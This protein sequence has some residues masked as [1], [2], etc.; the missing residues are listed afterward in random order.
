MNRS[1]VQ[2]FA[3]NTSLLL[4]VAPAKATIYNEAVSGD[5]SNNQAAPT[6]LMLTPGLNS[7]IGTVGLTDHQDWVSFT[8]PTGYMMT[9]YVNSKYNSTDDQ[10]FTGFQFGS[11]F[12]GDNFTPGSYAGYAHFGFAAN[13]PDGNPVAASTVGVDLLPLMANPNFAPG[14]TGFTPPLAAGTYTFLIQ[15]GGSATTGYQFDITVSSAAALTNISTRASVQTGQGVT[16][17]GFIV[18]GTDSK[19]VVLRGLGPT[20]GQPPFNVT[21]VLADPFLQLFDGSQHLIWSNDNWKDSQQTQ[22]QNLGAVCAGGTCHP[23]NDLEC[24]ILQILPPGNYTAIL[25]NKNNATGVGLVEVYD[26]ITG[27]FAELTNVSTRGFVGTD[28]NVLIAGFIAGGGNP[29]TTVV[30]RGLGPTLA[31]P[32]FNVPGV[33]ADPYLGL[34]DGNGNVVYTNNNWKDTQQTAISATG[35]APPNDLESAIVVTVAAGNYTAILSG[36]G[37]GTG[38]GLVEVYKL[39]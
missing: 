16:I 22:I 23:P 14:A 36:I 38:I 2:L 4:T 25:S 7:V 17:A 24:A 12:S 35:K 11:S 9:S 19:T 3:F 1:L 8:I 39:P 5:L 28:D 32:P 37:F 10:G 15:Q 13:N 6:A 33:L 29:S 18:T 31:Q 21:G 26:L 34:F 30:V 20:L 27:V